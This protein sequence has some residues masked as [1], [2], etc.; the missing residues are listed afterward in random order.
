MWAR[1]RFLRTICRGG[2]QTRPY[3]SQGRA[4]NANAS[5]SRPVRTPPTP[6]NTKSKIDTR[7]LPVYHGP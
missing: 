4:I 3:N 6:L 5:E 7:T 2:F 1:A